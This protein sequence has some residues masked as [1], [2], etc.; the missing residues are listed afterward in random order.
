MSKK[1]LIAFII[2][3]NVQGIFPKGFMSSLCIHQTY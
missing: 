2:A 1:G 3:V